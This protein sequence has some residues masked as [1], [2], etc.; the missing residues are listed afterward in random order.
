MFESLKLESCNLVYA[1]LRILLASAKLSDN[2]IV[3]E[4]FSKMLKLFSRRGGPNKNKMSLTCLF[5][6]RKQASYL[7]IVESA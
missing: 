5:H 3:I 2:K 1:D 6:K 4:L 7:I